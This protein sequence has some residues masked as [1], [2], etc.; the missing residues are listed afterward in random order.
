V[1]DVTRPSRRRLAA[2]VA[3]AAAAVIVP[4]LLTSALDDA[5][6][7]EEM[8]VDSDRSTRD[9]AGGGQRDAESATTTAGDESAAP[10]PAPPEMSTPAPPVPVNPDCLSGPLNAPGTTDP[11][12]GCWPGPQNTGYPH[13]LPGDTRTPVTLTDYAGPMTISD[14]G[15]VIDS[16]R[17]NGDL[18]IEA[19]NGTHSASTPCVTITNS[20]VLGT[21][22]TDNLDQ[23]PVVISDTEVAVP[24]SAF[25]ASVGFY[26]TFDWRINSHGGNGTI[27]CQAYCESHDSWVHGMHLEQAFHYNAF[28]GNGI[29][30]GDGYF[31]IDHGYAD[32]GSFSTSSSADG[33]A[34]CSAD[35]GFYGDFAPVRNITINKTY[36]APAATAGEFT[37]AQPGYCYNPG[38]YPGKPHPVAKNLTVT[39]NIFARGPTGQCGVYGA[40]S[41][42]HHGD[43]NVW[44]GNEWD[45]GTALNP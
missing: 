2:L 19:G 16:Q 44:R 30:T 20:L 5:G 42:W 25:W 26:N 35:I 8:P 17:V 33:T 11:W 3:L 22:H 37:N 12:G 43:G 36:F 39:N 9:T 1:K 40:V 15:V 38:N 10:A 34:G 7:R 13:G 24:G 18:L 4:V 29:E 23:G 14:C 27:K 21:V 28:G 31:T 45:D 32:C 6:S 41:D